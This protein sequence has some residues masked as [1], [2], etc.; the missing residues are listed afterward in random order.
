M[1]YDRPFK[2]AMDPDLIFEVGN[3]SEWWISWTDPHRN[4]SLTR[5]S[6]CTPKN[7][8]TLLGIVLNNLSCSQ[9]K[10]TTIGAI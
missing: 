1:P 8:V 3:F 4:K 2:D 7:R 10:M 9:E 5:I 6:V